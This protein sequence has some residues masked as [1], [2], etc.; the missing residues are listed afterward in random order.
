MNS[1]FIYVFD[2]KDRD[3]LLNDGFM[4]LKSDD[5]GSLFIFAADDSEDYDFGD[6]SYVMSNTLTF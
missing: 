5:D 4:L 1:Q 6:M 3:R 2:A